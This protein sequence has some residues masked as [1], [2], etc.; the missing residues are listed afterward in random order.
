MEQ[1]PE[2]DFIPEY[3]LACMFHSFMGATFEEMRAYKIQAMFFSYVLNQMG[4]EMRAYQD[5]LEKK[6]RELK[7]IKAVRDIFFRDLEREVKKYELKY[8]MFKELTKN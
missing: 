5:L 3:I 2:V 6:G 7:E 4:E 1:H 8:E